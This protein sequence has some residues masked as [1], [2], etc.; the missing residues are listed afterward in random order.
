M[1]MQ[2]PMYKLYQRSMH[3]ERCRYLRLLIVF[4]LEVDIMAQEDETGS[5]APVLQT[6]AV[7]N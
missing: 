7:V 5:L 3:L 6:S 1:I 4:A 2:M